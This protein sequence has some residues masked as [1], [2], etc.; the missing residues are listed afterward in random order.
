MDG[1]IEQIATVLA[2]ACGALAA[3]PPVIQNAT[4]GRI[5]SVSSDAQQTWFVYAVVDDQMDAFEF[6]V[7]AVRSA[8]RRY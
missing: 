2:L 4:T 5:V 6:S 7:L 1:R 8:R 3:F